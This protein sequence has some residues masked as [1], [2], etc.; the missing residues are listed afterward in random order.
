MKPLLSGKPF[1]RDRITISEKGEILRSESETAETLN[2]FSS[3]KV[4][5]LNISRYTEF[6][7]VT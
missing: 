6:D 1:I 5:Y 3:D 7:T 2:S 4:K